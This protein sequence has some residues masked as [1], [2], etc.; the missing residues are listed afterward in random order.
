VKPRLS[1]KPG[2][3]PLPIS[4]P[5]ARWPPGTMNAW[6]RYPSPPSRPGNQ[7]R[8]WRRAPYRHFCALEQIVAKSVE[9]APNGGYPRARRRSAAAVRNGNL[10]MSPTPATATNVSVPVLARS[11]HGRPPAPLQMPSAASELTGH[12]IALLRA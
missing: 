10:G 5:S 8:E 1:R 6:K 2:A 12:T 4:S 9:A 11:W 7:C 3:T